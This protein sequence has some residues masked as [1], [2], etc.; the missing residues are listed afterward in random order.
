MFLLGVFAGTALVLAVVGIYGVVAYSVTQRTQEIGIRLALGAKPRDILRLV[1]NQ[2]LILALSGI[3]I[4]L[5]VSW[6]LT[7]MMKSLLFEVTATD[8]ITFVASACLFAAIALL[9]SY[10]PARRAMGIDPAGALRAE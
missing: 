4:G 5:A 2:G 3:G 8:P 1:L 7:R 6:A 10:R 9:A